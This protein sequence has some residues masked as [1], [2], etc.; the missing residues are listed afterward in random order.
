MRLKILSQDEADSLYGLP[1]FTQKER[2]EY[3]TLST[4][5]KAALEQLHF[6]KSR[7][8]FILQ[9]GYFK[10]R[11]M[12]FVFNLTE[13]EEDAAYI[14]QRYFPG[15]DDVDPYIAKGT[16]LKQQGMILELCRYRNADAAIRRTLEACAQQVATVFGKP[17]YVFRELMHY[18]VEQRVVV[19]GYTTMQDIVGRALAHEQRRLAGIVDE[20]VGLS[21]KAA[22]SRLLEDTQGLHEITLLKRD[23][24]DFSNHEIRQEMKRGEH[25]RELYELS[26]KLLPHL[27]ISKENIRY[28]ASL[29]DYYS[30]YRLRQLSDSILYVYLLCFIQHRY[31]KLH[32]NLIQS[33]LH[34]VRKHTGDARGAAKDLVYAARTATNDDMPK[35]GQILKLFT[36]SAIAGSTP[37]EEVR[38]K[39]FTV[40]PEARLNAVAEYLGNEAQ[41]DETAFEWQHLDKV[42]HRFK[43]TLRPILQGIDF[44]TYAPGDL[45][46][47]AVHFMKE[48]SQSGK[49]LS[50]FKERDVPL[51]WIPEKMK[52]YIYENDERNRRRLLPNR[53]EFLLYR[54]LRNSM[55]A[56]DIFCHD[57]IRFRSMK[58]DLIG[59]EQWQSHKDKLI[60]EAGRYILQQPIEKHLTELKDQLEERIVEVNRRIAAGENNHFKRKGNSRWTLIYPGDSEAANHSFFDRLPQAD[61]NSILHFANQQ[62]WFTEAFTHVLSRF[63]K[64]SLDIPALI[65]TRLRGSR[66]SATMILVGLSIPAATARNSRPVSARS[67]L[68]IPLNT[69]G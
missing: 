48:A 67:M 68:A 50:A 30:V 23:P 41:F 54:Q 26:Q 36:D 4:E 12:F 20:H 58:D 24:R 29:V 62:C 8:F 46:M 55:E 17:V 33:L 15:L 14:R 22:L 9:L 21:A 28:Y 43:L 3:F 44:A 39:A 5:E 45:L 32:D 25:L 2:D 60:A 52:R 10:A 57:S 11:L 56:G 37:L 6:H 16:R 63:G 66:Y 1:R 7:L 49:P 18:L 69:G 27:N 19:P 65:A 13:V 64:Q 53:Y 40:L 51:R 34:H 47:E 35:G 59:E 61:I 42:A 31:Q 38:Q